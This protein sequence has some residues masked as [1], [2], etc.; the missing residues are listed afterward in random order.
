MRG[1]FFLALLFS[2]QVRAQNYQA[3]NSEREYFYE[4]YIPLSSTLTRDIRIDSV[5]TSAADSLFYNY[6]VIDNDPDLAWGCRTLN[7]TNWLGP[8][9]VIT[10]LGEN[11]FFNRSLDSIIIKTRANIG[12]TWRFVKLPGGSYLEATLSNIVAESIFSVPDSVKY[13]TLQAKNSANQNISSAFNGINL[14][15]SKNFGLTSTLNFFK[16]P[17]DTTVYNLVGITNPDFGIM[18][19]TANEIFDHNIGDIFQYITSWNNISSWFRAYEEF[20]VLSKNYSSALDSVTYGFDH[21]YYSIT[22]TS[23]WDSTTW[24]YHDTSYSAY[25]I[26]SSNYFNFLQGELFLY[27]TTFVIPAPG[28][29]WEQNNNT[30]SSYLNNRRIKITDAFYH[31]SLSSNCLDADVGECIFPENSYAEGLGLVSSIDNSGG[32]TAQCH[33]FHLVYFQ[34]ASE[35]W[36][37]PLNWSAILST[38]A[39]LNAESIKIYPNPFADYITIDFPNSSAKNLNVCL[40]N[41]LGEN[42]LS[43]TFLNQNHMEFSTDHI[44]QGIYVLS[45]NTGRNIYY[46][47]LVK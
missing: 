34:K 7:D 5:A 1:I 24:F 26:S 18:N 42:V 3:V 4:Y 41:Q 14:K 44:S 22:H 33:D 11:I 19:L 32:F 35:T 2:V 28:G 6:N 39:E 46:Y 38:G 27:D 30:A 37:T 8:L 31:I 23:P 9:I 17:T 25:N 10:S 13:I 40:R 16:L 36:G 21:T 15:L 29:Y 45:V 43:E 47:K 20:K 12:D